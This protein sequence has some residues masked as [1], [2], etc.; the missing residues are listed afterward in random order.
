MH[1][2]VGLSYLNGYDDLEDAF[3]AIGF[4]LDGAPLG[5]RFDVG[6]VFENGVGWDLVIGPIFLVSGDTDAFGLPVSGTVSY[7]VNPNDTMSLYGRGGVSF[8]LADGDYMESGDLGFEAALG[9]T[10]YRDRP[11]GFGFEVGYNSAT[12]EVSRGT[13]VDDVEA[14]GFFASVLLTF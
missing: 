10:F 7:T 1:Y 4:E 2:T 11:V 9:I 12:V 6:Q 5:V 3:N 8:I 14:I 13:F